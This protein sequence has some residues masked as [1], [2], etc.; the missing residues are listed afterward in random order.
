M[1]SKMLPNQGKTLLSQAIIGI[2]ILLLRMKDRRSFVA[3]YRYE[4]RVSIKA[5]GAHYDHSKFSLVLLASN[6]IAHNP[7]DYMSLTLA[8]NHC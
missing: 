1:A 7:V 8:R 6:A 4:N 3:N 5:G 2:E